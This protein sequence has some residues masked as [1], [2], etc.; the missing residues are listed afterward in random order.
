MANQL[1]AP[2]RRQ[3]P[4]PDS[5]GD[6]S[7]TLLNT[8]GADPSAIGQAI[9]AALTPAQPP[10]PAA[11]G[12]AFDETISPPTPEA[13]PGTGSQALTTILN[14]IGGLL[15]GDP[16]A[17]VGG[18]LKTREDVQEIRDRNREM[19]QNF[20]KGKNEALIELLQA[21]EE[22][23]GKIPAGASAALGNIADLMDATRREDESPS[24]QRQREA[25][26]GLK[27]VKAELLPQRLEL[28]KERLASIDRSRKDNHAAALV[29]LRQAE[30]G[31][32][33][34]KKSTRQSIT[35]PVMAAVASMADQLVI[36]LQE[37]AGTPVLET[38][39]G[40]IEGREAIEAFIRRRLRG[41]ADDAL[42]AELQR[43]V[44]S[45]IGPLL[46]E[47]E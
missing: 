46:D 24:L 7:G 15:Q 21:G 12:Q 33:E 5:S 41:I 34:G 6:L 38:A 19:R 2:A 10:D 4:I 25:G 8:L 47:F 32:E 13:I 22:Q 26:A 31:L 29:R 37:G 9:N 18:F 16:S 42:R 20:L 27:D 1:G 17:I 14:T 35:S 36:D 30:E 28:D 44:N 3:N 11:F 43:E 39:E 40:P 45:V 23:K